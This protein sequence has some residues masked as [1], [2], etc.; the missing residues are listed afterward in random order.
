MPDFVT[1]LRA[2]ASLLPQTLYPVLITGYGIT[3]QV[4]KTLMLSRSVHAG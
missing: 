2:A 1:A 3:E 4:V